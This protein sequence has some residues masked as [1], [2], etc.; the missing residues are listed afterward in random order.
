MLT[1]TNAP[2]L[3]ITPAPT[4]VITPQAQVTPTASIAST[5]ENV[6]SG[7]VTEIQNLSWNEV[8]QAVALVGGHFSGRG[9]RRP[10]G[11]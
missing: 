4:P 7:V 5:V 6:A 3:Q 10:T 9:P 1:A 11:P 2:Q 8:F